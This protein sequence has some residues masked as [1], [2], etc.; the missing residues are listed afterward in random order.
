MRIPF[1]GPAYKTRSVNQ[2]AQRCINWY[3]E[4]SE[5]G[6]R[7]P[8]ALYPTPG[9]RRLLTVGAGPIRAMQTYGDALY[10]VSGSGLYRV[11]SDWEVTGLGSLQT[12]I[13]PVGMAYNA[14][15]VLFVDGVTGY[16]LDLQDDDFEPIEDEDFPAGV[17]WA[18]Y[19]DSYFIV[20]GDGSGRFYIS[21][22]LNGGAWD[23][24]DFSSAEGDPDPVLM[25]VVDHR[26]LWLIGS[27]TIEVWVNTGNPDFPIE[28]QGNAFVEKGTSA[29]GSVVKLDNSVFWLGQDESGEG[30]VWR[31]DSY[32]P[33]RVST[34]GIELLIAHAGRV[35][36]AVA[37]AYTEAGHAFYVLTFPEA[38]F[39]V[40]YDVAS[41]EWHERAWFDASRG[42][43][44]RHRAQCHA[45]LGRT[46]VV[47][48]WEDGRLYALDQDVYTDDGDSIRR[49]R[50]TIG[51]DAD[52]R[53]IAYHAL[54]LDIEA[55]VGLPTGQGSDPQMMLRWSNDGGHTWSNTH[56]ASMG[57]TGEYGRR[58]MWRRLGMGRQRVWE[59]SVTDPVK[60]VIMGA[61]V[62]ATST[63]A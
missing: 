6:G 43:M 55:G 60:A 2:S 30:V 49:V 5:R 3:L 42:W 15:Q 45:V 25:G 57:K 38:D 50:T 63:G 54:Q 19:L 61:V 33:M 1:I 4:Q 10:V 37:Y 20:G 39:T 52:M 21:G 58:C 59:V 14:L 27:R 51:D 28:R 23:G 40:V 47:G 44:H 35:D 62:Q 12:S 56:T 46:H 13:G 29:P 34:H 24:T 26:E 32:N 7:T 16:M 48:D 31:A 53:N 11:T 18:A 36:D 22:V 41:G 9:L 8:A 17:T